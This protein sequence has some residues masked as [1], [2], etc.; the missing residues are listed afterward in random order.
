MKAIFESQITIKRF[1]YYVTPSVIMMFFIALYSIVDGAFVS[2]W[3]GSDALAAI[4]IMY[5]PTGLMFGFAIM[6]ATGSSA[7]VAIKLGEDRRQEAKEKFTL[8]TIAAA[9][10][11]LLFTVVG[12]VF[13]DNLVLALGATD[14]IYDYCMTYGLFMMIAIPFIFVGSIFEFF[15]RVDGRPGFT[16]ILYVSGG[17][18][19]IV[20]D[21]ILIVVLKIGIIGAGIATLVGLAVVA[22]LG[23]WYFIFGKPGLKFTVP[24]FD[25][26]FIWGS[27]VNGF[28][29]MVTESSVGVTAILINLI[30]LRLAGEDGVAALAVVMYIHYLMVSAYLGYIAGISPLI[31]FYYGAKDYL[32]NKQIMKYSKTFILTSS[33]VV[34]LAAELLAPFIIQAFLEPS[35]HAYMMALKGLRIMAVCFL[36]IGVNIFASGLFTAYAKGN[37]STVISISR[38]LVFVLIGAVVFPSLFGINGIWMILPFAEI[39]TLLLSVYVLK[40]YRFKYNY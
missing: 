1:L 3:V 6:M 32:V 27:L 5:P 22:L 33:A 16:L 10:I 17:V 18:I 4:G 20:L 13:L 29:E 25:G 19:N 12:I 40:K 24:K 11:G 28:P 8:I 7:I 34:F 39:I 38:G 15:I 21:Y 26:K 30:I 23:F 35:S 9:V 2:N 31:S 36:F 14:R 37:I